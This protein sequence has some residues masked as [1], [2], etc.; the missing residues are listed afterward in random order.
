MGEKA[1][2]RVQRLVWYVVN[3]NLIKEDLC[4]VGALLSSARSSAYLEQILPIPDGVFEVLL[5]SD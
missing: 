1:A 2:A 5:F 4:P 3:D